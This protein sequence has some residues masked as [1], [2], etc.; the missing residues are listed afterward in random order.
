[1]GYVAAARVFDPGAVAHAEDESEGPAGTSDGQPSEPV[2]ADAG[3]GAH[4][5]P[6]EPAQ[7]TPVAETPPRFAV[8]ITNS[9]TQS[10][11]DGEELNIPG[12][13]CE[14]VSGADAPIRRHLQRL[15]DCPSAEAAAATPS[16]VLSIG[17]RVDYAR[18]RVTAL[19][20]HSSSV[21]NAVAF[22]PCA[23]AAFDHA[24]DLW[25]VTAPHP[26]YL[27]FYAVR[28]AANA[29]A[30]TPPAPT[31]AEPTTHAAPVVDAGVSPSSTGQLERDAGAAP[32][33]NARGGTGTPSAPTAGPASPVHGTPLAHAEAAPIVWERVVVRDAPR[34]GAIVGHLVR[35]DQVTLLSRENGWFEIRFTGGTGWIF[36]QAVGR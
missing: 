15:G 1:M 19:P 30:V 34:T 27:Y 8:R 26:R 14:T 11:G 2:R 32:A 28:F 33:A 29:N 13:R 21:R 7:P 12:A 35:G 17:L 22:V 6:S 25:S 23:R 9:I 31:T 18:H 5:A 24:D 36:G 4:A 3:A 10:C 16:A 20:G